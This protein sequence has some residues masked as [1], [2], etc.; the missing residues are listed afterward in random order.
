MQTEYA[1]IVHTP[2]LLSGEARIDG[3]RI[4]VRDGASQ[5]G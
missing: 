4:R 1:H 3:H 5:K 2:G